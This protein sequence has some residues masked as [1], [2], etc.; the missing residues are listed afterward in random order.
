MQSRRQSQNATIRH[1]CGRAIAAVC[2]YVM[3]SAKHMQGKESVGRQMS[4]SPWKQPEELLLAQRVP[5][6]E[7]KKAFGLDQVVGVV[8]VPSC[9]LIQA[10]GQLLTLTC[11]ASL[12]GLV[13]GSSTLA[14]TGLSCSGA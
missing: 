14:L 11:G 10:I 9:Q 4:R 13:L 2:Q 6:W 5:V 12:T 7:Q 3:R 8:H 1:A